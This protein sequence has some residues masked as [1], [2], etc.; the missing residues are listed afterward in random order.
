MEEVQ[1]CLTSPGVRWNYFQGSL[2]S[3]SLSRSVLWLLEAWL[4]R[5]KV[6]FQCSILLSACVAEV[7]L[8]AAVG[9]L[10]L[11]Y[12]NNLV[13][14]WKV[15][16]IAKVSQAVYVVPTGALICKNL[17]GGRKMVVWV[18]GNE[19]TLCSRKG[20]CT[21]VALGSESWLTKVKTI[22]NFIFQWVGVWDVQ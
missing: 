16:N 10:L 7:A 22:A 20:E 21:S 15:K 3:C 12:S 4:K 18:R 13:R 9:E 14:R 19:F 6:F 5:S 1:N 11:S 8:Q 17:S 2:A